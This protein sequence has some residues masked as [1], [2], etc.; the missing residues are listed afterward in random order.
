MEIDLLLAKNPWWKGKEYFE[1]DP[2]YM[3]WK[4]RRIRWVPRIVSR[5]EPK[6]FS[7]HF[8][9]GPRQV[10]KTTALKFLIKELLETRNPKSVFYFRCDE[11]ANYKEL[12]DLLRTYIEFKEREVV[13]SSIILLDEI[14]FPN[15]WW[16]AVKNFIDDG[17]FQNDVLVLTGSA[18]LEVKKE[19][20]Y[21]PGRRGKGK[22]FV[23]WP[24][25]FREFVGVVD[26][27]L[28]EQLTG[29]PAKDILYLKELN[30]R[31]LDYFNC[32]GFPLAINSY[33]ETKTIEQDVKTTYLTWI[34]NDLGKVGRDAQI[35]REV[36]KT[37][38]TKM[39]SAISWEAIAKENSIKSPKTV[40][41]Y[42]HTLSDLFVLTLSHFIDPNTFSIKFGKN[43]KVHLMDPLYAH[44]FE[45]WCLV[46]MREKESTMAE[47][48]LASHLF[49]AYKEV[50]YW[51]NREEIDCVI[52]R[53]PALVGY[54]SK[55]AEKA[56]EK[57]LF[58]GRLKEIWTTSKKD[59]R[60]RILPLSVFLYSLPI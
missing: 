30:K 49:R 2:D 44:I 25:S 3:K 51:T 46:K 15:E 4:A 13:K 27:P 10:G 35:A 22:D 37:V 47:C 58:V 6:P 18:S 45:D 38:V 24:L 57:K 50:F 20:E 7:L 40:A 60:G 5:I 12:D 41:A 31:L 8:I 53:G 36:L 52:Q 33:F 14:T 9:F 19:T 29:N 17:L 16:R 42:L 56:A 59:F 39:P 43:K 55:W 32:G 54:E 48:L 28:A 21:F 26:S 23:M 1:T 34:K 11:L